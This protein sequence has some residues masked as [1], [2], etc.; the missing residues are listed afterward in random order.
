M[1]KRMDPRLTNSQPVFVGV[2]VGGTTITAVVADELGALLGEATVFTNVSSPD[3]T[4]GS[5]VT[6]VTTAL[7]VANRDMTAVLCL[8]LGIPGLVDPA[9]GQVKLAVNLNWTD[10]LAGSLL[11]TELGVP[12]FLEND[13][14][15]AA[16]GCSA[17]LFG[18]VVHYLAYVS[19]GTGL[20]A[21]LILDGQL[22]RGAHGMAGEI[23][24]LIVEPDGLL[25]K[26]GNRGC[27]EAYVSGPAIALAGQT[28]VQEG[29]STTLATNEPVT[30]A[31]V[32][33]AAAMYDP[34]A[35]RI[36]QQA[37]AY[38]GQALQ[39]LI[40]T[41][42]VEKIVLSGGVARNGRLLLDAIHREWQQQAARSPLAAVMLDTAVLQVA[43]PADNYGA[44]GAIQL[45]QKNLASLRIL[46]NS[47]QGVQG[48]DG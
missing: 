12:C 21:G 11:E 17:R 47:N 46:G 35:E 27:L 36:I 9:T 31:Q 43:S 3:R 22:Y 40:M 45:A 2:D 10:V 14:R 19:I 5:I 4:L 33:A 28:A 32:F 30:A 41:Y 44:W 16:L 26:C 24:H 18:G 20:A 23:G 1:T 15:V 29:R 7:D 25:C 39:G 37:G 34:V 13:V 6:A 48:G 8:G 42:D 38:L